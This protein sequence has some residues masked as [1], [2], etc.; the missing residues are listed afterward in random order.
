MPTVSDGCFDTLPKI[1]GNCVDRVLFRQYVYQKTKGNWNST[2]AFLCFPLFSSEKLIQEFEIPKIRNRAYP[3]EKWP[4]IKIVEKWPQIKIGKWLIAASTLCTSLTFFPTPIAGSTMICKYPLWGD[5]LPIIVWLGR[6]TR[7]PRARGTLDP[8]I[9]TKECHRWHSPQSLNST[10]CWFATNVACLPN[11][12]NPF[13]LPCKTLKELKTVF[14]FSLLYII[15]W[16]DLD[17]I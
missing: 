4:R 13:D 16:S 5:F 15:T 1:L 11:T 3:M 17:Q 7:I 14:I 9:K 2:Q 6:C 8:F 12:K 10:A